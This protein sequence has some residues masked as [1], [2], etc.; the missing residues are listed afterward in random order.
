M[1]V[2]P[3]GPS[4]WEGKPIATIISIPDEKSES[5]F[6]LLSFYHTALM[7]KIRV[8]RILKDLSSN[9]VENYLASEKGKFRKKVDTTLNKE[10]KRNMISIETCC[11]ECF[12]LFN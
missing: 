11:I 10:R 6:N 5:L 9:M 8:L 3:G 4:I 1:N 12:R 2:K 7:D